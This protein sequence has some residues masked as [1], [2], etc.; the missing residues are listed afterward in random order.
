MSNQYMHLTNYAIN[1]HSS[2]FDNH[3]RKLSDVW[4]SL[5]RMGF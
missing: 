5:Q 2:K 4:L 1:K 3:K